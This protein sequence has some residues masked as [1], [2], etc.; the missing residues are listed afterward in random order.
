M[1][2]L[3]VPGSARI[4][5][6]TKRASTSPR[7]F[8]LNKSAR[9][10]FAVCQSNGSAKS[11][12]RVIGLASVDFIWQQQAMLALGEIPENIVREAFAEFQRPA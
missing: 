2:V 7:S 12:A 10:T 8:S 5:S 6:D 3:V 4:D 1:L 9:V 11:A